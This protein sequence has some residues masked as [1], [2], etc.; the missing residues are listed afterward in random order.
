M[1]QTFPGVYAIKNKQARICRDNQCL[2]LMQ[3]MFILYMK[4]R[5]MDILMINNN[6]IQSISFIFLKSKFMLYNILTEMFHFR[7]TV[8]NV[9]SA[10]CYYTIILSSF[11]K[12]WRYINTHIET[13]FYKTTIKIF[14]TYSVFSCFVFGFTYLTA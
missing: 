14:L 10:L 8:F 1:L 4:L 2:L 11:S 6:F 13:I 7:Y 9:N 3:I 5:A 12:A